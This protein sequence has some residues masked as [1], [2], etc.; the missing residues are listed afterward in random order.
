V[1][2]LVASFL[3]VVQPLSWAMTAP[4]FHTF[5]VVLT[6]WIFTSRRTITGA[7]VAAG[8]AGCHHHAAFHRLFAKACWSLDQLG[9]IVFRRILLWL[10]EGTIDLA[11]DDTLAHKR[12]VKMFGAGMHHDAQRSTRKVKVV[13]W[14][15]CWVILA[16]VVRLPFCPDRAF[17][18]PLLFR[19]YLNKNASK[20]WHRAYRTRPELAVEMLHVLCKAH[21]QR[22]FHLVVDSAYGGESVLGYRPVNCD[23]TSRLPMAARL[24]AAPAPR[25]PGTRGRPRKRGVRLPS[26]RQMLRQRGRRV[27]LHNYGDKQRCRLVETV[28]RWHNL[29]GLPLKIVVIEPLSGGKPVQA[30][31]STCTEHTA[32]QVLSRYAGRWSIE[33]AHQGGKSHLGFEEPQGWSRLAVLRTA[34]IAMLLYSLIV[35]WFAGEGQRHY[36]APT[37]PW[38]R[39]KTRPSFADMLTTLK[40][41]SLR[42]VISKHLGSQQL[43]QNLLDALL[44]AAQVPT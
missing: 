36:R 12:G 13:Q 23:M 4:S 19:L 3:E 34:P 8:V 37:R 40:R 35:L 14:G 43:P 33:E 6:G 41:E 15:H 32:E 29:P 18:L 16:V 9:L 11:V 5:L 20:R 27:E 30:F 1:L 26:P 2:T 39:K 38:Y 44:S 24:Y 17:S 25:K 28:A 7:I 31:Y 22:H 10:P 42:E 21:P